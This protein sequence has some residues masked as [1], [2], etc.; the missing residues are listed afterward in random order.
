MSRAPKPTTNPRRRKPNDKAS[1]EE[2]NTAG[3]S[4]TA[5]RGGRD[6]AA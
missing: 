1:T 3:A 4:A 2:G 6:R 5:E